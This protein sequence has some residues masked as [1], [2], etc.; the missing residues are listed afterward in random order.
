MRVPK[1]VLLF[2]LPLVLSK[3]AEMILSSKPG[4]NAVRR[5]GQPELTTEKGIDLATDYS[6]RAVGALGVAAIGVQ[7]KLERSPDDRAGFSWSNVMQDTA[8]LLLAT[9]G[10]LRISSEFVRD[11]EKMRRKQLEEL[12][13]LTSGR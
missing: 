8:D 9:G 1:A 2:I 3:V 5:I 11:K 13:T 12:S 4:K 10:L 6:K 7:Q